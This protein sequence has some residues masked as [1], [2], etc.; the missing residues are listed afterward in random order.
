M[1]WGDFYPRK[2]VEFSELSMI[3]QMT[4][5]ICTQCLENKITIAE[6]FKKFVDLN[7]DGFLTEIQY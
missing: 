3:E 7:F 4:R 5:K 2:N 6:F 1:V